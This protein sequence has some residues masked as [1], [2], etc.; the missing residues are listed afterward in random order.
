MIPAVLLVVVGCSNGLQDLSE[1]PRDGDDAVPAAGRVRVEVLPPA[2]PDLGSVAA[3]PISEVRSFGPARQVDLGRFALATPIEVRGT[4]VGIRPYPTMS[5]LPGEEL[6]VEGVVRLTTTG[7]ISAWN[8][9]TGADGEFVALVAPGARHALAVIPDDPLLPTFVGELDDTGDVGVLEL[10]AGAALY[11]LVALDGQP[12]AN[13]AV[14]AEHADGTRTPTTTSDDGGFYHL[15]VSPGAWTVTALG[16]APGQDPA[17]TAEVVVGEDGARHDVAY[18][19]EPLA[20]LSGTVRDGGGRAVPDAVVR[21]RSRSLEGYGPEASWQG[22][23]TVST[24]GSWLLQVPPGRY[25]LAVIP[26]TD[27][28]GTVLVGPRLVDDV[29]VAGDE[30][31]DLVT[32]RLRDVGFDVE[33]AAGNLVP[34]ARLACR[35]PAVDDHEYVAFVDDF[36]RGQ[37]A[38]PPLPSSC[39]LSPPG[40][41]P[42]LAASFLVLD[43]AQPGAGTLQLDSGVE[44]LGS[45][46]TD[47]DP[48]P[49]A[50]VRVFAADPSGEGER[51]LGFDVTDE[52][53][54][55][56][57]PVDLVDE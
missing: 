8:S 34:G 52:D 53:G 33:D 1:A 45:V 21:L 51:M 4:V 15:R 16:R 46:T 40:T 26:P 30:S 44:V 29:V 22:E 12:L 57:V 55:F 43:G 37:V 10:G 6:P 42:D 49:G 13:A 18:A 25:D 28:E 56:S 14:Y 23:V 11:G 48:T 32:T 3:L 9:R 38:L 47:G 41:R 19:A 7:S 2:S 24:N 54:A 35:L 36:G 27:P 5:D 20:L 39:E 17:L 50:V 31:L